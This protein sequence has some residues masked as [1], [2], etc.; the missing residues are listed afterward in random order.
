MSNEPARLF[1][2]A[3]VAPL[4][5]AA[6]LW[7]RNRLAVP[8][9]LDVRSIV[10]AAVLSLSVARFVTGT[11]LPFSGHTLFL[12]YSGLNVGSRAYRILALL[13]FVE[14]TWFKLF[15]WR[16]TKSWGIGIAIG[17]IA[18]ALTLWGS[19]KVAATSGNN[20]R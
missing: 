5:L 9:R 16:D 2:I 15:L 11:I 10:D 20:Q 18:T 14:T 13:L 17:L 1:W 4:F 3:Y 12:T 6:P 19:R 7:L 8:L